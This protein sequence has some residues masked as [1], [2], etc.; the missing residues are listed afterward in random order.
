MGWLEN[1]N[2][3]MDYIENHLQDKMDYEKVAQ[4][5]CC[6]VYHFQRMFTFMTDITL[7]EYVRRRK[8]T[9]AAF[10]LQNSDM[11]IVDIALN[12]GYES[13]EAFTRAFHSL[14]GIPPTSARRLGANIKAFPRISFQLTIKGVSEMNYKIVEKEAFQVYGI[15]GIFDTKDDENL[16]TIPKF[17]LEKL[18]NGE[19]K[20]LEKSV[21]YTSGI[22]SVCGYRKMEGT[23]FPY[24][25]CVLKKPHSDT[26]GYTVVDVP[27]STWAVF[28]NEP[29]SLEETSDKVQELVSRVY[30]EW[31][32]TANYDLIGGYEFEMYYS[33]ENSKYYEEVWYRI[34]QK[35]KNKIGSLGN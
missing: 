30:T 27:K 2:C 15:E 6:S 19:C 5:A 13:P 24:M 11:K 10:Q 7:S 28:T 26:T 23:S 31:I 32:P 22:N 14:H 9:L 35:N 16:K 29:H 21:N 33:G 12:F 18:D 3:A 20:K 25:L 34:I 4:V 17:W 1:M 8:M